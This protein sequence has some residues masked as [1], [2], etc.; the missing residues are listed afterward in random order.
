M[1]AGQAGGGD[2]AT[3]VAAGVILAGGRS[4]RMGGVSKALIPLAGKPLLGHVID[5]VK[6]QVSELSLSVEYPSAAFEPYGLQQLPDLKPGGGPL[7]GLL[8][9]FQWMDPAYDW[10]LLVPCDAPFL[11]T[12]LAG[13]LYRRATESGL[14]GAVVRYQGEIQPTFSLWQRSLHPKL[15]HAV[16]VDGL[17]GFKQ[18]LRRIELAVEDWPKVNLTPFFNINDREGL[19]E[20]GR[21]MN[22]LQET[23]RCSA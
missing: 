17:A 4:R 14:P 11:P 1:Q 12:D 16:G 2:R 23:T 3:I 10:L 18:F 9:A 20:A 19:R 6:P 8:A 21:L 13:R 22:E 5:R 15:E 7:G